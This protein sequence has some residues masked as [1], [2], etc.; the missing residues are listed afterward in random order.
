MCRAVREAVGDDMVL[1]LDPFGVYTLDE[2]IWVGRSWKTHYYWLEHP[3]VELVLKHTG[4]SVASWISPYAH[5]NMF[6]AECSAG[7]SGFYRARAT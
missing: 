5:R 2:S 4:D 3:M 7:R 1:M 6:R